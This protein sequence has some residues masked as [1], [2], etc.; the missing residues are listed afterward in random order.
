RLLNYMD[1][2]GYD[3]CRPAQPD[4]TVGVAP[5]L[6][7]TSG[8]VRRAQDTMPRQGVEKPWKNYQNYLKD[9]INL[10]LSRLNDGAMRFARRGTAKPHA[11]DTVEAVSRAEGPR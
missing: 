3:E 4:A 5:V 7:L 2:H 6:N 9:F 1:R 11:R 8:Y 10:R